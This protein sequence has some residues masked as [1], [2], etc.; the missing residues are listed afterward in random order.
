MVALVEHL[1]LE[2]GEVVHDE[3]LLAGVDEV[4]AVGHREEAEAAEGQ[5]LT[6]LVSHDLNLYLIQ[7]N[8]EGMIIIPSA[9]LYQK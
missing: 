8:T 9:R 5:Q 2:A 6:E 4:D 7:I 1:L 3:R